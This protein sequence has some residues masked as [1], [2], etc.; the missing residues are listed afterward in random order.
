MLFGGESRTEKRPLLFSTGSVVLFP[1]GDEWVLD[2]L[3]SF[4]SLAYS[5]S[6]LESLSREKREPL[7][8]CFP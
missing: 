6:L 4:H 8:A 3:E 5:L 7:K 2:S 1:D